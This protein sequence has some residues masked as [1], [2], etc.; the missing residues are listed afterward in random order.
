MRKILM[1][2]ISNLIQKIVIYRRH[3]TFN[4]GGYLEF[5]KGAFFNKTVILMMI[6]LKEKF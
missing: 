4:D 2:Q 3:S 5:L 6:K 1:F